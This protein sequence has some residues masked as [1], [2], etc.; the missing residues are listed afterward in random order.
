MLVQIS[1]RIIAAGIIER[2]EFVFIMCRESGIPIV[3]VLSGGY[4]MESASIITN[5]IN[6]LH[7]KGIISLNG[8]WESIFCVDKVV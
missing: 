6:N 7:A 4:T 3:M 8:N 5:S 1:M 2:D